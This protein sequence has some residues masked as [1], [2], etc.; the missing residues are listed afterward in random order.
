M[1]T[2]KQIHRKI[3]SINR[4]Y[5]IAEIAL[6]ELIPMIQPYFEGEIEWLSYLGGGEIVIYYEG[7]GDEK[8]KLL[9]L[10]IFNN[11]SSTGE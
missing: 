2:E 5:H 4:A 10:S 11:P 1:A 7:C 9:D 6:D 8:G 3:K